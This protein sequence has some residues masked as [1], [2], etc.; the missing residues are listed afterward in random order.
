MT[1]GIGHNG[2]P[3][4]PADM[5][6]H[7]AF[8]FLGREYLVT[9][10]QDRRLDRKHLRVLACIVLMTD[11]ETFLI[12]PRRTDIA[13]KT[14]YQ[15]KTVSNILRELKLFGYVIPNV[16]EGSDDESRAPLTFGNIDHETIRSEITA[17][18]EKFREGQKSPPTGT[19]LPPP[20]GTQSPLTGTSEVPADR[21]KSPRPQGLSPPTGTFLSPP[22]GT[23]APQ[24]GTAPQ[25]KL[26]KSM[27]ELEKSPPTGTTE[28]E[29]PT[30][31]KSLLLSKRSEEKDSESEINGSAREA[32]QARGTRLPDDWVLTK[33][34]G[35]WALAHFQVS[36]EQ[37]LDQAS[38]FRDYWSSK[39]GK[40]A[41]KTDWAATWRNWCRRSKGWRKRVGVVDDDSVLDVF[42]GEPAADELAAYHAEWDKARAMMGGDD[43]A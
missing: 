16:S 31:S 14:G 8:Y 2:G 11:K 29:K 30:N 35:D 23:Q 26:I 22:A 43:E 32:K 36:R 39:A 41:R 12:R 25:K 33:A 5:N 38:Q 7:T 20:I 34:M 28:I 24:T 19:V 1:A 21:D 3:M 15:P 13:D 10:I 37:V 27:V 42:S 9:A 6:R 40:E 4:L 18:V 17:W